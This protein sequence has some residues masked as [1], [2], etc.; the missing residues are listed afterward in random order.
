MWCV[1][2]FQIYLG[3]PLRSATYF[4]SRLLCSHST[5]RGWPVYEQIKR[6]RLRSQMGKWPGSSGIKSKGQSSEAN[7]GSR[8][9]RNTVTVWNGPKRSRR[10]RPPGSSHLMLFS[11]HCTA[12][13][14]T[15]VAL[16]SVTS[17][18]GLC[19]AAP[20]LQTDRLLHLLRNLLETLQM[21]GSMWSF[22]PLNRV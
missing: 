18:G 16:T 13:W 3:S 6:K 21:P 20:V 22:S 12:L 2:G 14:S 9:P 11:R 4:F 19:E 7:T 1:S 10:L 15:D 17:A 5:T 8:N